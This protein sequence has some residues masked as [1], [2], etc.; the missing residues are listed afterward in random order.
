MFSFIVINFPFWRRRCWLHRQD[1]KMSSVTNPIKLHWLWMLRT[2]GN[3]DMVLSA[4]ATSLQFPPTPR[5]PCVLPH[6]LSSVNKQLFKYTHPCAAHFSTCFQRSDKELGWKLQRYMD[7]RCRTGDIWSRGFE[8][9]GD[10]GSENSLLQL[11]V[12][13]GV[14][15]GCELHVRQWHL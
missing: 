10:W 3:P 9:P 2:T 11:P 7:P 4:T 14:W 12:G 1:P 6:L 15:D 8:T 5:C 13:T